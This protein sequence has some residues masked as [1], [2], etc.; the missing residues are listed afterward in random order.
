MLFLWG[1][2]GFL[3]EVGFISNEEERIKL[4]NEDYQHSL[5][6]TIYEGIYQF[7]LQK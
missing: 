5:V 2:L 7:Y 4:L 3:I 6:D 1:K